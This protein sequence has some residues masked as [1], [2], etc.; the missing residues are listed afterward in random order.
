MLNM[1]QLLAQ[2]NI[3]LTLRM[4]L[5]AMRTTREKLLSYLSGEAQ[6]QGGDRFTIPYDRQQLADYLCVDR[7]AMST[8]L[9]RLRREGSL[10]FKGSD[11]WLKSG[12]VL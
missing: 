2:K 8:A 5:L 6:R 4:E 7:S 1:V 10:D 11:F 3:A 12:G 9:G